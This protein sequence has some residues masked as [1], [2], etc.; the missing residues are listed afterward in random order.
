MR[1]ACWSRGRSASACTQVDWLS[2]AWGEAVGVGLCL[3]ARGRS[4]GLGRA[5]ERSLRQPGPLAKG[6]LDCSA[7]TR[8][9]STTI[10]SA[11]LKRTSLTGFSPAE[12][13][14]AGP[15]P[16][17]RR[18]ERGIQVWNGSLS[19]H[20]AAQRVWS[21]WDGDLPVSW[22]VRQMERVRDVRLETASTGEWQ[23]RISILRTKA[24][25]GRAPVNEVPRPLTCI[26][27]GD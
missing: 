2:L 12:A 27:G 25:P 11:R 20:T 10:T 8:R 16:R 5:P 24:G 23:A 15:S 6:G 21:S 7:S 9:R 4:Y 26:R 22:V 14:V 3:V 1:S 19:C 13:R 18:R 17:R